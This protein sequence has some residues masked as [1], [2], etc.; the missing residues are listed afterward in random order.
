V[1]VIIKVLLAWPRYIGV[2]RISV[3][4]HIAFQFWHG[5]RKSRASSRFAWRVVATPDPI[6]DRIT[7][8]SRALGSVLLRNA[9]SCIQ[10]ERPIS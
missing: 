5:N 1:A 8:S 6:G 3:G 10:P 9:I 4:V 7:P 2:L